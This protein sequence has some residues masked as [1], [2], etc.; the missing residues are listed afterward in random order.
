MSEENKNQDFNPEEDLKQFTDEI[1]SNINDIRTSTDQ[2][3]KRK[4]LIFCV[5]WGLTLIF[6]LLFRNG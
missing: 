4:L 3:F 1:N 2:F 6:L 5:R